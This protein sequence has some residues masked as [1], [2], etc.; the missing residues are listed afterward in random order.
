MRATAQERKAG[1]G[2]GRLWGAVRVFFRDAWLELKKVIWPSHDQV[3]KMTGLV[4]VVVMVVSGF[5]FVWDRLLML[6]TRPMFE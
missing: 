5:I 2:R 3:V 1:G 4:V 6:V